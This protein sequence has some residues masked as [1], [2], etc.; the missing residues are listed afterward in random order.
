MTL[1]RLSVVLMAAMAAGGTR[2]AAD[3]KVGDLAPPLKIKEWVRGEAVNLTK[4]A[5]KKIHMVE[6][7]AT[8]CPPC[9]ASVPLLTQFQKKHAKDLVI[10][11]VTDPDP[12]RNSPTEI[13][14]FVKEQGTNMVYTIALD[15][16]GATSKAYLP[17]DA[18]GIP[19]AYL[20]GRDGRVVWEGSPLD[21]ALETVIPEV[22]AGTFDVA[23]AKAAANVEQAV[24]KLF[25]TA[26]QAY[27]MGRM[28]DVWKLMLD[29]LKADPANEQ[30][31]QL[32]TG[33][34]A[35]EPKK[36][37]EF[38]TAVRGHIAKN[39][40][41][42]KAMHL[43]AITLCGNDDYASRTPDLALEAAKAAY[44]A[45]KQDWAI[46]IYAKAFYQIGNLDRA[47]SLQQ[48]AVSAA[49]DGDRAGV[50]GVLDY[51]QLCKKLQSSTN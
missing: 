46:E 30:A 28:D 1:G 20:V 24:G 36:A 49:T 13:K 4:D 22:I 39:K 38:K 42:A 15:D 8:W 3:L 37:E 25:Q 12:Y 18:V 26:E 10:I 51:Y 44:E 41:N 16:N 50:Q 6:F 21:P 33:L 47:I 2:V 17:S 29:I 43:L 23:K 7:W 11:G 19:Y 32:L 34:Y 9:K 14:Q 35:S 27:Q 40:S 5:A 31:M 48:E 45:S